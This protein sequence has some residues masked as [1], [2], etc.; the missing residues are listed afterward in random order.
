MRCHNTINYVS[1]GDRSC[2][3]SCLKYYGICMEQDLDLCFYKSVIYVMRS[4][5]EETKVVK[6]MTNE[7]A[8]PYPSVRNDKAV[9]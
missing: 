1:E 4:K 8:S 3:D 9:T 7:E 2:F 6:G 5:L